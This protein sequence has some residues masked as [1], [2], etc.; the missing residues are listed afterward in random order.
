MPRSPSQPRAAIRS[1]IS[2]VA[3]A[4]ISPVPLPVIMPDQVCSPLTRESIS[5]FTCSCTTDTAATDKYGL[6]YRST[7]TT[8]NTASAIATFVPNIN[9]AGRYDL[10]VWY[11][12]IAKASPSAQFVVSDSTGSTTNNVN[13]S[14]GTGVWQLLASSLSFARGTNG[15]VR[16]TNV[17]PGGKNVAADAVRWVCSESQDGAP[18][19]ITAQP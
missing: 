15:F 11:P 3:T 17:G 18:P 13:E 7:S 2:G 19:L 8:P 9:T 4:R 1:S 5:S 14:N 6:N 10:Y 16:L 12:T